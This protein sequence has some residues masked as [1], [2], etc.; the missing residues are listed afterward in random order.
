MVNQATWAANQ[1]PPRAPAP[2]PWPTPQRLLL[3]L[4]QRWR[5]RSSPK[6]RESLHVAERGSV[7]GRCRPV[8]GPR[9]IGLPV[10]FL[11]FPWP[12]GA[13][14]GGYF[15]G[16]ERPLAGEG[17]GG[18]VPGPPPAPAPGP[19]GV[20]LT[21]PPAPSER[22]WAWGP[23]SRWAGRPCCLLPLSHPHLRNP[24]GWGW[25][26]TGLEQGCGAG[27]QLA[28]NFSRNAPLF[29]QNL[30]FTQWKLHFYKTHHAVF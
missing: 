28:W 29:P 17:L 6:A 16:E 5:C 14:S 7:P 24:G 1:V 2:A 12:R 10:T 25:W 23:R 8:P 22:L 19:E 4:L 9:D 11:L 30:H 15:S 27:L 18:A 26:C 21:G 13:L 3:L 20:K